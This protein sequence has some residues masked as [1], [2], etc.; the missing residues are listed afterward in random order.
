[1][2]RLTPG[3]SGSDDA[4]E[5]MDTPGDPQT[6]SLLDPVVVPVADRDD[7][8]RTAE[9]MS[10]YL[11]EHGASVVLVHV[12]ERRWGWPEPV[13]PSVRVANADRMFDV[14]SEPFAEAGVPVDTR[15]LE[16]ESV[17]D[18]VRTA[19]ADV[20]AGA[21]AF[22]PRGGG[23][24]VKLLSGNVERALHRVSDRPVLVVEPDA[25]PDGEVTIGR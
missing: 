3:R 19:A 13:S 20:D 18:A 17:A 4:S 8:R 6:D 24:L 7:A 5:R 22:V 25:G 23:R 2:V 16:G 12:V 1:M 10:P 21:I 15:L 11:R 14:A 9:V